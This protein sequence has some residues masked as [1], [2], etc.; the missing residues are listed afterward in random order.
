[1]CSRQ[2]SD[3]KFSSIMCYTRLILLKR[4]LHAGLRHTVHL[5]LQMRGQV[6]GVC[7]ILNAL[8]R[9]LQ[10]QRSRATLTLTSLQADFSTHF[11]RRKRERREREV[12][13]YGIHFNGRRTRL[14]E[15]D[16]GFIAR[17]DQTDKNIS[18]DV[19]AVRR[20]RKG[21]RTA[22]SKAPSA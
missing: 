10:I 14:L 3:S 7:V 20:L 9:E 5:V 15:V 17:L 13:D 22:G 16:F 21:A 18:P 8:K 2:N 12:S 11:G 6:C 19:F 1:M 4:Q